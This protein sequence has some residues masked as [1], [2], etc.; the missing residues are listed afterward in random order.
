MRDAAC[1]RI[2]RLGQDQA[3]RR[4]SGIHATRGHL[5]VAVG[6]RPRE[7][8]TA[9]AAVATRAGARCP[10][11]M[12]VRCVREHDR[13]DLNG[14]L[15]RIA[16]LQQAVA[17]RELEGQRRVAARRHE[18]RGCRIRSAESHGHSA[19]LRPAERDGIP[20]RIERGRAVERDEDVVGNRLIRA[21]VG[22][23]SDI[24]RGRQ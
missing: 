14:Y 15:D 3:V 17:H 10:D 13:R 12:D 23:G 4:C 18:R 21:R 19:D 11:R 5:R 7:G 9:G 24:R 16:V 6:R 1:A 2:E 8:Q 22:L 20:I